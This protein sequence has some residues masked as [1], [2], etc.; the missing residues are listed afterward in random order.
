MKNTMFEDQDKGAL[1]QELL[2]IK[3]TIDSYYDKMKSARRVNVVVAQGL[4][5]TIQ[6]LQARAQVIGIILQEV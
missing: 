1:A 6:I 5:L 2:N 4:S 3:C